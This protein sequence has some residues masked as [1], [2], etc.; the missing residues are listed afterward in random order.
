MGPSIADS[1][2]DKHP[3]LDITLD[4]FETAALTRLR[5]LTYLEAL[6]QRSLPP[7]Q[8]SA[9]LATYLKQ[10]LPLSSNTARTADL[11]AERRLDAIGHWVLRLS[12]CRSPELRARFVRAETALFKHRFETDDAAE[13][14]HFLSTLDLSWATVSDDEKSLYARQLRAAMWWAKEDAFNAETWFKVP[15]ASVPDLVAQRRVFVRKGLAY[16]PQSMQ[17]SLVLQAFSARLEAALE[18]SHTP[19]PLTPA[20]GQKPAPAGRGRAPRPRH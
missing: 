15:W 13:R 19:S 4:E 12:F 16:V 6:Q 20:H 3:T 1:S 18:V 7:A 11:D 2:Y 10:H 17:I 5:V 9:T 14:A 8:L